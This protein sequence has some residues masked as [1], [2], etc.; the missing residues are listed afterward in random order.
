MK[1]KIK[2]IDSQLLCSDVIRL[3]GFDRLFFFN[4]SLLMCKQ[5]QIQP[6]H[7]VS[8]EISAAQLSF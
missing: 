1:I 7:I 5:L 8:A 6:R 2:S 4:T 3:L